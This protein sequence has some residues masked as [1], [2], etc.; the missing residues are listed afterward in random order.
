VLTQLSIIAKRMARRNV[1]MKELDLIETFGATTI[2]ASDKTGT[3][4]KNVMTVTDLWSG[5]V[6]RN[7][8]FTDSADPDSQKRRP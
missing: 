4:T 8:L 5:V 2:I 7:F 3:L 1:Y 6:L